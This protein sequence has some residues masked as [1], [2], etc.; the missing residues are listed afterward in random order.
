VPGR[1]G[2]GTVNDTPKSALAGVDKVI[3]EHFLVEM[4]WYYQ[5]VG[6]SPKRENQK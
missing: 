3:L 6:H 2:T 4:F 1:P 5:F